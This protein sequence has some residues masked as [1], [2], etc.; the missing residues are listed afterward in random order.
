MLVFV[1]LAIMGCAPRPGSVRDAELILALA[2]RYEAIHGDGSL[3]GCQPDRW[4]RAPPDRAIQIMADAA[5]QDWP[6]SLDSGH[7]GDDLVLHDCVLR[8]W[9]RARRGMCSQSEFY[10]AD[11]LDLCERGCASHCFRSARWLDSYGGEPGDHQR[12]IQYMRAARG[13]R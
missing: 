11:F 13:R 5:Q 2:T 8:G 6:K 9:H 1:A 4:R 12:A 10:R 7:Y 3:F